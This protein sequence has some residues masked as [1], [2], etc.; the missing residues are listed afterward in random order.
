MKKLL[1]GPGNLYSSTHGP[2][3]GNPGSAQIDG[4]DFPGKA[5]GLERLDEGK[6]E[7]MYGEREAEQR[8]TQAPN[9]E[10]REED[11]GEL[12][13]NRI[14]MYLASDVNIGT[15][16]RGLFAASFCNRGCSAIQA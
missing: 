7:D 16:Q 4:F 1:I 10:Q 5:R 13:S 12:V 14:I 15:L 6:A 3:S 8:S 9:R 11:E 2:E